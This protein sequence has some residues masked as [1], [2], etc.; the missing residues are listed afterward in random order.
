MAWVLKT[1]RTKS[2]I[3]ERPSARIQGLDWAPTL[4]AF[5]YLWKLTSNFSVLLSFIWEGGLHMINGGGKVWHFL[6]SALPPLKLMYSGFS[7]SHFTKYSGFDYYVVIVRPRLMQNVWT[8]YMNVS[9]SM[10]K[11]GATSILTFIKDNYIWYSEILENKGCLS[12]RLKRA[13]LL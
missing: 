13:A 10:V 8:N 12:W 6:A 4:L 3:P 11:P 5:E 1:C 2:S 7:Y 9:S